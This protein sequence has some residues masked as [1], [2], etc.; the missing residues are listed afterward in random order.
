LFDK[1]TGIY[2]VQV[3]ALNPLKKNTQMD[4]FSED[5]DKSEVLDQAL[6]NIYDKFGPETY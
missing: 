6:E 3:T 2:Q 4:I 5:N 1:N